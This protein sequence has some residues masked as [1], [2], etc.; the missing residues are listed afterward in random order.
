MTTSSAV[1]VS[2]VEDARDYQIFALIAEE[3]SVVLSA[4]TQQRRLYRTKLL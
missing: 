3:D 1:S 4:E 2:A